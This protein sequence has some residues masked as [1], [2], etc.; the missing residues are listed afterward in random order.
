[1]ARL[2]A[3]F[4]IVGIVLYVSLA[5]HF[6]CVSWVIY[7]IPNGAEVKITDDGLYIFDHVQYGR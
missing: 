4:S 2:A 3:S 7:Y 1:M 5:S 6:L